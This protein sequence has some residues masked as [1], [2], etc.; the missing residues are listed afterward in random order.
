MASEAIAL[1]PILIVLEIENPHGDRQVTLHRTEAGARKALV[2]AIKDN[3]EL[4]PAYEKDLLAG[5][6]E[7]SGVRE[8]LADECIYF[9]VSEEQVQA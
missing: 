1:F 2:A 5:D 9:T 8:W 6:F 7:D 3:V 4:D